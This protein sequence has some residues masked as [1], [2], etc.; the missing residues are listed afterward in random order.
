MI[1]SRRALKDDLDARFARLEAIGID[2]MADLLAALKSKAT[3]AQVASETD[4]SVDY[5]SLLRREAN[6]YLPN[7][8]SLGKLPNV[9][10]VHVQVLADQGISNTRHLLRNAAKR[11]A[12]EELAERTGIPISCLDELA[13][14]SD[15]CRL[16]GVGPVFARLLYD[17]GFQ[18]LDSLRGSTAEDLVR[19]YEERTGKP[20][21]FGAHE[22]QVTLELAA[23]LD[24]IVEV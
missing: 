11:G 5:L 8:A 17:A 22:I 23:V 15:L 3:I 7:P 4:L 20:A 16:Y 24:R 12:R 2:T 10:S 21:D 18:T 1:P 9:D 14:L 19:L 13:C 6:S